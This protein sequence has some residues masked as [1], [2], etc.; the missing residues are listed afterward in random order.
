MKVSLELPYFI[1]WI[2]FYILMS[3]TV[4]GDEIDYLMTH[5]DVSV[6]CLPHLY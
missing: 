6:N 2:Y 1:Y 4:K 3:Y 5:V